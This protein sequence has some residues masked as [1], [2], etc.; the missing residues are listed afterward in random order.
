VIERVTYRLL[1]YGDVRVVTDDHAE[2]NTVVALGA[3]A[4]STRAFMLEVSSILDSFQEDLK[5]VNR[6]ERRAYGRR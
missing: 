4:S 5:R 2:Q 1:D 6:R 3:S